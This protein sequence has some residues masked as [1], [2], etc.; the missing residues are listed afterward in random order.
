MAKGWPPKLA[1]DDQRKY[2]RHLR[3][4]EWSDPKLTA[5]EASQLLSEYEADLYDEDLQMLLDLL[6][7]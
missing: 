4:P 5:E 6:D 2:L 3:Y 7:D 1:T